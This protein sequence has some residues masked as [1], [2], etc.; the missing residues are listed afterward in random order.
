VGLIRS[1]I[2]K[3]P[4]E[5][6][7]SFLGR[8]NGSI[9]S[10]AASDGRVVF[11]VDL[12]LTYSFID[13]LSFGALRPTCAFDATRL[14]ERY[15]SAE[16][17]SFELMHSIDVHAS[18]ADHIAG[19]SEQDGSALYPD[20]MGLRLSNHIDEMVESK[21]CS[22]CESFWISKRFDQMVDS[23]RYKIESKGCSDSESFALSDL[24]N[25]CALVNSQASESKQSYR[26]GDLQI[27]KQFGISISGGSFELRAIAS[28]FTVTRTFGSIE[29]YFPDLDP[30]PVNPIQKTGVVWTILGVLVAISPL[31]IGGIV[32]L[33]LNHSRTSIVIMRD[34]ESEKEIPA[35]NLTSIPGFEIFVGEE[36]G[37]S[38]DGVV[39]LQNGAKDSD[40]DESFLFVSP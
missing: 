12:N 16:L 37:P 28:V 22:D 30:V 8:L 6:F 31:I 35:D 33:C 10:F 18:E 3:S 21:G 1:V 25:L 11:H 39:S 4:G 24:L 9:G 26:P 40:V 23:I 38:D 15:D 27:S 20:S 7:F 36:N 13:V 34:P 5:G 2:F 32:L 17:L 14:V 29:R 19:N